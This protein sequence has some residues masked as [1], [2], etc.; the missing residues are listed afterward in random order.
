MTKEANEATKPHLDRKQQDAAS[1]AEFLKW[2]GSLKMDGTDKPYEQ[3]FG[4]DGDTMI[5]EISD[6][7]IMVGD[8]VVTTDYI[9]KEEE[10]GGF[11]Y[12]LV[13]LRPG[14][15]ASTSVQEKPE[16]LDWLVAM[17][18]LQPNEA[19]QFKI[20]SLLTDDDS[21]L[22]HTAVTAYMK[23]LEAGHTDL[24]FEEWEKEQNGGD[25]ISQEAI[26]AMT[27]DILDGLEELAQRLQ[28][29]RSLGGRAVDAVRSATRS[30]KPKRRK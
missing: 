28:S 15:W 29:R 24:S 17:N 7:G 11:R 9:R 21:I 1:K 25:E 4:E 26:D 23:E 2:W 16:A 12:C 14:V 19:E 22:E 30:L 3:P 13:D 27:R 6:K 18:V 5:Y 10:A 8:L 20:Q